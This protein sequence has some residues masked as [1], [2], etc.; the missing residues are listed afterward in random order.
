MRG[1]VTRVSQT[2]AGRVQ[3]SQKTDVSK[4]GGE[5]ERQ[6]DR[7]REITI[8]PVEKKWGSVTPVK[9]CGNWMRNLG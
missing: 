3:S 2:Y 1:S 4:R 9:E 8:R 7:E 5:R 6:R